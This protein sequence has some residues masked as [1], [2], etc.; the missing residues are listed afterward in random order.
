MSTATTHRLGDIGET[1]GHAIG[2]AWSAG[3]G[4]AH[5]LA[6]VTTEFAEATAERASG[7]GHLVGAAADRAASVAG[8]L[9]HRAAAAA[10]GLRE[11][12]DDATGR[13]HHR[14]GRRRLNVRRALVVIGIV[15]T[16][17]LV[18]AA[19][20]LARQPW[21]DEV[22]SDL[23]PGDPRADRATTRSSRHFAAAT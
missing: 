18:V 2:D 20:R 6:D 1:V 14:R 9:G 8:E 21:A 23:E 7:A 19:A 12:A 3:S 13:T 5:E 22:E 11:L 17:A 15:A 10:S 16:I 4:L